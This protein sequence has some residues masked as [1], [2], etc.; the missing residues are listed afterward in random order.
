VRFADAIR[1]SFRPSDAIVRYGGDEFLV[2]A[3]GLERAAAMARVDVLRD[4]LAQEPEPRVKF[5][6]GIADLA[7][8]G[9]PEAALHAADRAM[10]EIKK[11]A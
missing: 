7:A 9:S 8:G 6:C 2:V 4:R 1:D 3:P 10:Y 5:S 11:R